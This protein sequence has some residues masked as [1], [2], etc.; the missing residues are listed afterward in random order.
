MRGGSGVAGEGRIVGVPKF[1]SWGKCTMPLTNINS[2]WMPTLPLA[3]E[4]YYI[5]Q[6]F[7]LYLG[8]V[9]INY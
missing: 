6:V 1:Q 2:D 8:G 7:K 9:I 5:M 3:C 4:L